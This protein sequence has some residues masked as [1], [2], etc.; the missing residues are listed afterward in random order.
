[1]NDNQEPHRETRKL[2]YI[3]TSLVVTLP[4]WIAR[5][6]GVSNGATMEIEYRGDYLILYPLRN[7]LKAVASHALPQSQQTDALK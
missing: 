1:M 5:Q 7:R 6:W 4:L 3:G 2:R